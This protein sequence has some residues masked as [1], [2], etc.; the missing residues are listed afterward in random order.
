MQPGGGRQGMFSR[1]MAAGVAAI[2]L[3]IL[4]G[5]QFGIEMLTGLGPVVASPL[6]AVA[7]IA[8]AAALWLL[9]PVAPRTNYLVAGRVA[10]MVAGLIGIATLGEHSFGMN[11]GTGQWLFDA[12]RMPI[13]TALLFVVSTLSLWCLDPEQAP[14]ARVSAWLAIAM[15]TTAY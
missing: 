1:A 11:L 10:A 9:A 6:A 3:V 2:A 14:R 7:L 13:T 4:A 12:G 15:F 8:S 5:W